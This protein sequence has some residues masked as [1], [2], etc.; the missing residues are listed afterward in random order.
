MNEQKSIE[1]GNIFDLGTKFSEDF[2]LTF[3]DTAGAERPVVIGCY[4]LG[5]SRL[6]GTIVEALH[7]DKG[8]IWPRTVTPCQLHLV[9]IGHDEKLMKKAEQTYQSLLKSGVTVLFDDRDLP[10]GQK[11]NDAD[12]MGIS[13]RAVVSEKTQDKIEIKLRSEKETKLM[14]LAEAQKFIHDYYKQ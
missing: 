10:A 11:L 4:G 6:M 8:I 2:H 5:V 3:K 12:L 7:D 1:A 14:S 13:L 9:T